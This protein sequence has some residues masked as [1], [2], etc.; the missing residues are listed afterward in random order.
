MVGVARTA[1][2]GR[3]PAIGFDMGG[4]STDVSQRDYFTLYQ[5]SIGGLSIRG[6]IRARN[7]EYDCRSNHPDSTGITKWNDILGVFCFYFWNA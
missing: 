6:N 5:L 7:A 4:T 2:D 1:F 3:I